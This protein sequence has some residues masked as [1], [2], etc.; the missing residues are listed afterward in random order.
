MIKVD[1]KFLLGDF[2]KVV[3]MESDQRPVITSILKFA[4]QSNIIDSAIGTIKNNK[5]NVLPAIATDEKDLENF[6]EIFFIQSGQNSFI[7]KAIQKYR[8]EKIA[9]VGPACIMD[10]INKLQYYGIGCNWAKSRIAL[11]IGVFCIGAVSGEGLKCEIMETGKDNGNV[12]K[13]YLCREGIVFESQ[14]EK[15]KVDIKTHYN[16]INIG[17]KYCLNLSARGVDITFIPFKVDNNKFPVI[18]RSE[19]GEQILEAM[20]KCQEKFLIKKAEEKHI[21]M[22]EEPLRTIMKLNIENILERA[23]LNLPSNKWNRERFKKFYELW[24]SVGI[25]V[26]DERIL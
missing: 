11:K 26:L 15:L 2:K 24:N 17:C 4:F 3:L 8:L 10:V 19:R 9:V 1:R 25:E 18:I 22:I 6:S 21:K 14:N 13:N 23:E 7:K 20:N 5:G 12:E 16:Y